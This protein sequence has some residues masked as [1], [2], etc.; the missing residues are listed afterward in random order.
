M[1]KI[2]MLISF[3]T[4]ELGGP[5]NVISEIIP[6]LEKRGVSTTIFTTSAIAKNGRKRTEFYEQKSKNFRI[7]KFDKQ[8]QNSI[9]VDSDGCGVCTSIYLKLLF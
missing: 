4:A 5:Y 9:C 6:Y 7:T 2:G 3:F 1:I 8:K